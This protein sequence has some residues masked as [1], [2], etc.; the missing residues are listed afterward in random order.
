M[1]VNQSINQQ[2][3]TYINQVCN[4]YNVSDKQKQKMYENIEHIQ[5]ELD[6]FNPDDIRVSIN[7]H[8]KYKS[9]KVRPNLYQILA[10]LTDIEEKSTAMDP[11]VESKKYKNYR[12]LVI[13]AINEYFKSKNREKT[14]KNC[15][16]IDIKTPSIL[17]DNNLDDISNINLSL[18][19]K[20]DI[21]MWQ[22]IQIQANIL[23][24][25]HIC[26]GLDEEFSRI[27]PTAHQ[28]SSKYQCLLSYFKSQDFANTVKNRGEISIA[29]PTDI[30]D[31][32][33]KVQNNENEISP[34][35][36][37]SIF[38]KMPKNFR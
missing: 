29:I 10:E 22:Y 19:N 30:S 5:K 21:F 18:S 24:G 1:G 37:N 28:E 3:E 12:E 25:T 2:A 35:L 26:V 20:I 11:K 34:I 13:N 4:L 36:T 16:Y 31:N 27:K 38:N 7:K 14:L 15:G 33:Q 23:A 9:S 6:K 8:Y 17:A 32:F